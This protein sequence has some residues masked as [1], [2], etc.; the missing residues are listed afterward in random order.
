V[1]RLFGGGESMPEVTLLNRIER[2]GI[3]RPTLQCKVIPDRQYAHD[4]GWL[5]ERVVVDVQG[6]QPNRFEPNDPGG[7]HNRRVGYEND[8]RKHNLAVAAGYRCLAFTPAM[9]E[10]GEAVEQ[11]LAVLAGHPC[12]NPEHD[13]EDARPA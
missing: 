8:Q 10:S 13:K 9:I 7:A 3:R 2:A 12:F 6:G 5:A 4:M 11:I 1:A